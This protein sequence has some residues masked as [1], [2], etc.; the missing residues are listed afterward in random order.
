VQGDVA[1][2]MLN[3]WECVRRTKLRRKNVKSRSH[4]QGVWVVVWVDV[5]E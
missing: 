4:W 1:V 5:C 3:V 2:W